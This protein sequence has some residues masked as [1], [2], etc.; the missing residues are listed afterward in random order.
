MKRTLRLYTPHKAQSFIHKCLTRFIVAVWGRQ[1]GKSTF[2]L[3]EL[4]KRAW[5]GPKGGTYW[6]VSPTYKAAKVQFRRLVKML[7]KTHGVTILINKSELR[8]V[9][10]NRAEIFF[11][12]GKN[13]EDLRGETLNG[14]VLDEM[15]QLDKRVWT[16]VIRPMLS[17]TKGWCLFCSTPNG[18]DHFYDLYEKAKANKSGRWSTFHAPSTAN[19]LF[20]QEEYDEALHDM[21]EDEF[22][23]EILAQFRNLTSGSAYKTYGAHNKVKANPFAKPGEKW[24]KYLPI[25]V[26]L[27]FNVNPMCWILGQHKQGSGIYYGEEIYLK[28][29][30]TQEAAQELLERIKGHSAGVILIGD[31]SGKARKT[32][33][34]G[35]T[36]YDLLAQVL[37]ANGIKFENKTPN[38]NPLVKDRVNTMNARF[39][40]ADGTISL[41]INEIT[42]PKAN[43]DFE[44]VVWKEGS[45]VIFDKSDPELTHM[46]DGAGYPVCVLMP[47]QSI[48]EVGTIKVINRRF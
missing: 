24:S 13:Y 46:S 22:A 39:K 29:T 9:L 27:D 34:A 18:F 23:Q 10:R 33:A 17:T 20:T 47:L 37:K 6:Y 43:K 25:V 38:E 31:A 41:W 44:R 42:C 15:R 14:A 48:K 3:N 5:R 45:S 16:R 8:I 26:G 11:V 7:R 19:P 30:H 2:A 21:S 4:V 32:S 40:A 35:H 1:S 36:D 28:N 12:S